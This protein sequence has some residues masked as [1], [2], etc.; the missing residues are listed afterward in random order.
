MEAQFQ[1]GA[2]G[3]IELV[4]RS[5]EIKSLEAYVVY[6]NDEFL[7]ELG[8]DSKLVHKPKWDGDRGKF[9]LVYAVAKTKDGGIQFEIMGKNDVDKIRALSK[10]PNSEPW[11]E[12]YDE[13]A[14]KTVLKK[15][16]KYLPI[17]IEVQTAINKDSKG[18]NTIGFD[19]MV[20]D[21]DEHEIDEI[22]VEPT[23]SIGS[24][25]AELSLDEYRKGI[26]EAI[27]KSSLP[28]NQKSDFLNKLVI[29]T[30]K[31][32]MDDLV[33]IVTLHSQQVPGNA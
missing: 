12:F 10:S 29:A 3:L 11:T 28:Q 21:I 33:A 17:S 14:R 27:K 4:R 18:E 24:K 8:L 9:M 31:K 32:T 19:S 7:Y 25:E 15:I 22:E 5:G 30:D 2:R 6:E 23:K 20:V 1:L 13:M 26:H 16:C